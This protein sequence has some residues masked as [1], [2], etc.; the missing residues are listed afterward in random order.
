MIYT[1]SSEKVF[2]KLLW[3][4]FKRTCKTFLKFGF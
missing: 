4:T 1:T 3:K 2:L